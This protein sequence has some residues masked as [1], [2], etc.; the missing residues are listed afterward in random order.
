MTSGTGQ[1]HLYRYSDMVEDGA[2]AL[3]A[4]YS[5]HT[6]N[7]YCLDVREE[8][9]AVGA[10]DSLVSL[11]RRT[12]GKEESGACGESSVGVCSN[13]WFAWSG[14]SGPFRRATIRALSRQEARTPILTFGT[15]RREN[16]WCR[17]RS[18]QH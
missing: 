18:G 5:G 12:P 10:A 1:V 13:A 11:W 6:A 3:K 7:C 15:S 4:S 8:W 9:M 16:Y 14:P 2:F 17:C